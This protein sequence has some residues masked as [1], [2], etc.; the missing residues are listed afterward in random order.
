MRKTGATIAHI[1]YHLPGK[2]VDN[3]Q[4]VQEFGVWTEEKIYQK[5]GVRERHVVDGEL[6]SDLAVAAG[7][8]LFAESGTLRESIDF[9]LLCTEMPD[10]FLP[11]TACVVHDRLG[12][13]MSAGALDFNL[14]CSGFIYGLALAKGLITAELADRVL[15]IT[16]DTITRTINPGDKSTRTIFGDGAAATLVVRSETDGIGQFVLGT[17]GSGKE[18]LIIPAGAWARP[19]SPETA[20]TRMN[21]WGNTRSAEN[22]Y[23]NGPEV[24]RFTV[25]TVPP[26]IAE[27]LK[28]HGLAMEDIDL[29]VFHQATQLILDHLRRAVGIPEEKFYKNMEKKGN[30][31][32]ATIPIALRDAADEGRLHRGD[33]VLIAGFGV[34]YSWGNT[35]LRWQ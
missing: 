7:E 24:L 31:V 20:E 5:T 18:N 11:A 22:V 4:L 14:G 10:Y 6:V 15:L 33:R 26:S 27:T 1:S 34:G 32:S 23:M 21:R 35:V 25:E 8:K 29:A 17:D 16:A 3:A 28:R 19:R 12:L 9:L 13:R 2:V 30:T